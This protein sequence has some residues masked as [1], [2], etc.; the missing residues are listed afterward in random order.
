MQRWLFLFPLFCD[1][2]LAGES[3]QKQLGVNVP[4]L[5]AEGLLNTAGGLLLV[6]AIIVGGAWLFKRYAQLPM[7]G[8]GLVRVVGGTSVGARERVVVVEVE[9]TRLLLGV[10][11][12]H[13]STLHVLQGPE[14]SFQNH[15]Q[16]E[17]NSA[18][19]TDNDRE[20]M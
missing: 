14:Q 12:G 4:P 10:A 17:K 18:R 20:R 1:T 6:L 15:L 16:S 5:G 2:L 13:V 8:K 7:G 9:N 3:A 11:Q 19:A